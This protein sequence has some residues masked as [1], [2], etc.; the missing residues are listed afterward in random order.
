MRIIAYLVFLTLLGSPALADVPLQSLRDRLEQP[1]GQPVTIVFLGDSHMGAFGVDNPH[2][3]ISYLAQQLAAYYPDYQVNLTNRRI[4]SGNRQTTDIPDCLSSNDT[5]TPNDV[6]TTATYNSGAPYT[7]NIIR[8]GVVGQNVYRLLARLS[9]RP[10]P[11]G[12]TTF[13]GLTPD[14]VVVMLGANDSLFDGSSNEDPNLACFPSSF[15]PDGLGSSVDLKVQGESA[16]D[17]GAG[18]GVIVDRLRSVTPNVV[19]ATPMWVPGLQRFMAGDTPSAFAAYV[20]QVKSLAAA[21]GVPVIDVNHWMNLDPS[22]DFTSA[23]TQCA[24]GLALDR[25]SSTDCVHL[26]SIGNY[27]FGA[28]MLSLGFG[29]RDYRNGWWYDPSRPGVGIFYESQKGYALLRLFLYDSNGKST[30]VSTPVGSPM[31]DGYVF[32]GETIGTWSDSQSGDAAYSSAGTMNMIFG[33]GPAD[34]WRQTS[35]PNA[36]DD[37]D[38][39]GNGM[40]FAAIALYPSTGGTSIYTLMRFSPDGGWPHPPPIE[41]GFAATG[42]W[43]GC[44]MAGRDFALE[45]SSNGVY[46]GYT[47][48]DATGY[49]RWYVMAGALSGSNSWAGPVEEFGGGQTFGGPYQ[50]PRLVAMS[51][52]GMLSVP[53]ASPAP[54]DCSSGASASLP[55]AALGG[56]FP[57]LRLSL[58]P[59]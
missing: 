55:A 34:D 35:G 26:N 42:W 32:N 36:A 7:L 38:A 29:L 30:A 11:A 8:D 12:E 58:Y 13:A 31:T 43:Q 51:G 41:A 39:G 44:N 20:A 15:T 4:G 52:Q 54:N 25:G 45:A 18:L 50:A 40:R 33:S 3:A 19:L 47:A 17:Y 21:K 9:A 22:T 53:V 24:P 6:T 23:E 1:N 28:A 5:S 48:F 10:F 37:P 57:L 59:N 2:A 46:L 14:A 27:R 16:T 49:L 56:N